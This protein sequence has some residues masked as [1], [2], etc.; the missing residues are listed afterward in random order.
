MAIEVMLQ[1][2]RRLLLLLL[3]RLLEIIITPVLTN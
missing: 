3:L 2:W 1:L